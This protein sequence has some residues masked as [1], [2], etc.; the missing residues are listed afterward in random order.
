MPHSAAPAGS[1]GARLTA[2]RVAL[3]YAA[4]ASLWILG[5]DWLL[6]RLVRDPDWLMQA[7]A[8]KGWGFVA[9]TALLLYALLRRNLE[10]A[11]AAAPAPAPGRRWAR[12]VPA[13]WLAAVIAVLTLLAVVADFG[14][15]RAQQLRQLEALTEQQSRQVATWFASHQS[16][17]R[18]VSSSSIYAGFYQRW[19]EG[20]ALAMERLMDRLA[21]MRQ[22]FGNQAVLV[23]DQ[24]GEVLGMEPAGTAAPAPALRRQVL[25]ALATGDIGQWTGRDEASGST[26]IDMVVPVHSGGGPAQLAVVLRVALDDALLPM[27][28]HGPS[29]LSSSLSMLVRREGDSLVGLF[30]Q[31]PVPLD[32]P[33][34]L[35]GRILSG[36]QP[37]GRTIEGLDYRGVPVAGVVRLVPGTAWMLVAQVDAAELRAESLKDAL[38][39][40]AT[41]AIVLLG[42]IVGTVMQRE[43]RGRALAQA[44]RDAQEE[45]LR[46]LALVQAI[47]EGSDDAIFAKDL[48]GRY[49][50]CNRAASRVLGSEP[51]AILGTGDGDYLPP[52]QAAAVRANDAQV[53]AE[54]RVRTY[55]EVIGHGGTDFTFL[56]TKGPLRD[57]EGHVIGMF[58]IS[59]DITERKHAE[60]A[61]RDATALV[62]AVTDS[63]LDH[64][65]VLDQAGTIVKVNAAWKRFAAE[66]GFCVQEGVPHDGLGMSYLAIF[67]TARGADGGEA[68]HVA[69]G[70]AAVLSGRETSFSY[71]YASHSPQRQRWFHMTVTPLRTHAGG[72]VVVHSDITERHLAQEQLRKLSLA[73]AQ[74]PIGIAIRDTTGRIEYVNDA[75]TRISGYSRE[76]LLGPQIFLMRG[77]LAPTSQEGRLWRTL[78]RGQPWSGEFR[79]RRKDGEPCDVFVHAAPIRQDDGRI[80]H[81]LWIGE[82]VTEKKRIG[83]ELDH[84]RHRLQELVQE[85]TQQLQQANAELLLARDRADA[86]SRAKSAFLANMSHEIRTPLNAIL[87]LTHL[88]RR[89]VRDTVTVERLGRVG[90]AA[91]LLLQV[92]NDVL[93][94]SKIE[95]GR[96]EL[97]EADFSLRALLAGSQALVAEQAHAK[98]LRLALDPG[99]VPDALHGD[100]TRL[101][102]ALLNL[103][104]N[105][106]KFTERGEVQVRA[107]V[108]E[109]GERGLRLG[110]SVRDTGIGIA[111][112]KLDQVFGAF[113]Q[114]DASTTRRFGGSGLGLA[115]TQRLAGLMGGRVEVHSEL[116]VGSEF[117]FSAWVRESQAPQAAGAAAVLS[118]VQSEADALRRRC[119]GARVLLVEDNP[120]SQGVV[121]ELLGWAGLKVDLARDGRQA[122]DAVQAR[123]YDALLMDLQMPVMDG[124]EAT[125]RIRALADGRG[126]MPILAMTA[127]AF[128]EDRARCLGA[129]MDDHVPK[130]VEPARLFATLRRWLPARE[131]D[132][133][134]GAPPALP[135]PA[136]DGAAPLPAIAGLDAARA[137]RYLGGQPALYRRV[138]SQFLEH[139]GNGAVDEARARLAAGD[140]AALAALV[141]ALR[142]SAQPIGAEALAQSARALERALADGTSAQALAVAAEGV[143]DELRALLEGIRQ[144]LAPAPAP[145]AGPEAGLAAPAIAVEPGQLRELVRLLGAG[146]Y[147]A[148]ARWR[149]LAPALRLHHP[150]AA[151]DIEARLLAFDFEEALALLEELVRE[152]APE[153]T[154]TP[155]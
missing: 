103:L 12:V 5:S 16:Q 144:A 106:V 11:P 15:L 129:G 110:L 65:A 125:R 104:S 37:L 62:Q 18:F 122:L 91:T 60:L 130:P 78:Q 151:D 23:F 50:L 35:V 98:Q 36:E 112:D 134:S 107:E 128:A 41:G 116:G 42:T 58:G 64:M 63:V 9:L 96:V 95:A 121:L 101:S 55:E 2:L 81:H 46:A 3:G 70:I 74:S 131:P 153:A 139:Y 31:Q 20:D 124:L 28:R 140:T 142:G 100:P 53:M 126:R 32:R 27:L 145:A 30:G 76:E 56:A 92:V 44:Q 113:V 114:E 102:Q 147:A 47:A 19:R 77:A 72:A 99:D 39:I 97:E 45:R 94:L 49:L 68:A 14:Q 149:D 48:Q 69:Q 88:M 146:N 150:A 52:A 118:D 73:V 80:T 6:G 143:L 119:G 148:V 33:G 22:A 90:N 136:P 59:R 79:G 84:H 26:W 133:G 117:R 141:H 123:G 17:A 40:A 25:Q 57:D 154:L 89:D 34:L 152:D 7:G 155:P 87:G 93:D 21:V 66:N 138:L 29:A 132:A 83:A 8:L 137:L 43:R 108:L 1:T 67:G 120:V 13:P 115:I 4:A 38:W 85:R 127:D 109:R 82:D 10:P 135:A 71:E 75:F 61:L 51:Q 86:A 111:P 24:R 54:G 105:A